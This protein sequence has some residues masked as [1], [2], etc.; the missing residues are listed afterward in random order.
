MKKLV[1]LIAGLALAGLAG[2][3]FAGSCVQETD[4]QQFCVSGE[5][6]KCTK[7]YDA[8]SKSFVHEMEAYTNTGSAI[9][10]YSPLYK[11]TAGYTPM[12]CAKANAT[13][14]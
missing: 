11:K 8:T 1:A 4:G 14:S 6:M 9:S 7:H 10:L 13:Q 2:G 3:A 12:N 5:M